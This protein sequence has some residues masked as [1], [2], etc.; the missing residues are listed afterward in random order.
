MNEVMSPREMP[1]PA[2][3]LPST[4]SPC[5]P[6]PFVGATKRT[7][8]HAM[9]I[10]RLSPP[11]VTKV[12]NGNLSPSLSMLYCA[13]ALLPRLFLLSACSSAQESEGA[14]ADAGAAAG[15]GSANCLRIPVRGTRIFPDLTLTDWTSFADH[16]IAFEV[17]NEAAIPPPDDVTTRHEGYVGRRGTLDI[18]SFIW[19]NPHAP[20]PPAV[21]ETHLMGWIL[22]QSCPD[23]LPAYASDDIAGPRL[24]VGGRYVAAIVKLMINADEWNVMTPG[25]VFAEGADPI[26]TEDIARTGNNAVAR[27][28]A[29]L[30]LDA[31]AAR[32]EATEPYASVADVLHLHAEER[33]A[34]YHREMR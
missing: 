29:G 22:T 23:M 12:R 14:A 6:P 27:E 11:R 9:F 18:R 21:I 13:L 17:A 16:V 19:S 3:V 30:S 31:V 20:P 26:A 5:R 4:R 24:E 25:S 32:L 34:H 2:L 10:E 28:F 7:M 1:A 33:I 15:A 8:V